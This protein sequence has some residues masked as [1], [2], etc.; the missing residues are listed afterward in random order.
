MNDAHAA[1]PIFIAQGHGIFV[2]MI[3]LGGLA[4]TPF[5][6]AYGASKFGLRG[7][8][9]ALRAELDDWPDIYVCDVYPAFVD[10]PAMR[11]AGN[12]TGKALTIPSTILDPRTVAKVVLALAERP[13]PATYVGIPTWA[14]RFGHWLAPALTIRIINTAFA[15]YFAQADDAAVT[16]GNLFDPPEDGRGIDGGFRQPVSKSSK[17]AM[18]VV[19]AGVAAVLAIG[20]LSKRRLAE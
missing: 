19:T 12:Y 14:A 7:F 18:A 15:R 10:T 17:A 11:H 5:S 2:N 8:T 20:T 13:R 1:L 3:S 4:S 16:A 9:E 6:A